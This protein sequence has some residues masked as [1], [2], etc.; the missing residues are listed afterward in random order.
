MLNGI[1]FETGISNNYR[2]HPRTILRELARYGSLYQS[3][4][5]FQNHNL[6]QA[7]YTGLRCESN[8]DCTEKLALS[9][10]KQKTR[11]VLLIR[12]FWRMT[13]SKG[14]STE[15]LSGFNKDKNRITVVLCVSTSGTDRI[16]VWFI[17]KTKTPHDCRTT[18][19]YT[20]GHQWKSKWSAWMN[21]ITMK[22]WLLAFYNHVGSRT[23]L[24]MDN[25][26]AHNTGLPMTTTQF[27][28]S[29][30]NL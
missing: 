9:S 18:N 26:A 29:I 3:I 25:F 28:K 30:S 12:L 15:S 10:N 1:H 23:I 4:E 8:P 22:E 14:L 7:G 20:M 11:W 5:I 27:Y 21:M 24:T 17:D 19:I 6:A 2:D 13:P 16:L